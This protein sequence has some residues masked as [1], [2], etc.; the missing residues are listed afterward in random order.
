MPLCV[1]VLCGFVTISIPV[2]LHSPTTVHMKMLIS[3][4]LNKITSVIALFKSVFIKIT[5][6]EQSE[7]LIMDSLAITGFA[8]SIY[9][10]LGCYI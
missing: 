10:V 1:M 3:T 2:T 5:P 7:C 6:S 9:V 4:G 8:E